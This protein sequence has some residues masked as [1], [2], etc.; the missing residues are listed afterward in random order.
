MN[1][2]KY[3]IANNKVLLA[4]QRYNVASLKEDLAH[5]AIRGGSL[6]PLTLAHKIAEME[7]EAAD[8]ARTIAGL[9]LQLV[10]AEQSDVPA[11][12]LSAGDIPPPISVIP[13]SPIPADELAKVTA[14]TV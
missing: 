10:A 5:N 11:P 6:D 9:E 13:A 1:K 8:T 12:P 3:E 7:T 2:L 14:P 4:Q